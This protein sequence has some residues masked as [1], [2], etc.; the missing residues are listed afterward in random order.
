[1]PNPGT[2]VP[3]VN[4]TSVHAYTSKANLSAKQQLHQF[5]SRDLDGKGISCCVVRHKK[6]DPCKLFCFASHFRL[7]FRRATPCLFCTTVMIAA[8][9]CM[10]TLEI[11]EHFRMFIHDASTILTSG[12]TIQRW[13]HPATSRVFVHL[14]PD[15]ASL[16]GRQC[17]QTLGAPP[18]ARKPQLHASFLYW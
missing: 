10:L 11:R 1:M 7:V 9:L 12:I 5:L 17:S 16:F 13:V 14:F 3:V 15:L 4:W 2:Q 6:N 8:T 18:R